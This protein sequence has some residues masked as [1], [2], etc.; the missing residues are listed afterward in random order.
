MIM[1]TKGMGLKPQVLLAAAVCSDGDL[2]KTFTAED[3]LIRAWERNKAAWGLRGY[4]DDHP[5]PEKIYKELNRRGQ[6]GL[7]GLGL[8]EQ[9]SPLVFRLTPAGL[10]AASGLDPD[11]MKIREKASR[12]LQD[13]IKSILGHPVFRAWLE[14]PATPKS[15]HKVGGFWG[16]APGTPPRVARER[17]A[18]VEVTLQAAEGLLNERDIQTI[19]DERGQPLF[20]RFDIQRCQEFQREMKKRFAKELHRLGAIDEVKVGG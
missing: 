11:D 12:E 14:Y 9:V 3:L 19:S 13:Q 20:D 1:D 8:L 16:I 17:V 15:F 10:A 5:D 4:E 2:R 18:F 6:N 7:V